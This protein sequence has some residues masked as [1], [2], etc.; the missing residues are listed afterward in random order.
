[1]ANHAAAEATKAAAEATE[2]AAEATEAAAEAETVTAEAR[3]DAA[4][5]RRAARP[6]MVD[7]CAIP[8]GWAVALAALGPPVLSAGPA[9]V[10][11]LIPALI[12]VAAL[13]WWV[14]VVV[15]V[16]S[17]L[18]AFII[19]DGASAATAALGLAVAAGEPLLGGEGAGAAL[20]AVSGAVA[21]GIG[22]FALFALVDVGF[23]RLGRDALGFGDVKL[24]GAAAV[25][26]TPGAAAL[27]LELAALGAIAALLARPRAGP[28]RDTAVPFGAFLAP[29]AWL[30]YVLAPLVPDGILPR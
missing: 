21:T 10:P 18:A 19:P 29:A 23:R 28:L 22:A 11:A 9:P 26:L 13:L 12:L 8:A 4:G 30:V 2:A 24:A 15:T 27:A 16:R 20:S 1:M 17:D 7:R 14:A 25:W 3:A 5:E 6:G